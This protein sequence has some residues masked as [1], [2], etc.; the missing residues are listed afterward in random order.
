[1]TQTWKTLTTCVIC[2]N[3]SFRSVPMNDKDLLVRLARDLLQGMLTTAHGDSFTVK[4]V[5]RR[6]TCIVER[7][8]RTIEAPC[9][10][11]REYYSCLRCVIAAE[12]RVE[13]GR[14]NAERDAELAT[15][16]LED[17]D[18]DKFID[19]FVESLCEAH[20]PFGAVL[21]E[22]WHVRRS[23]SASPTTS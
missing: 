14:I 23:F 15:L 21:V 22:V 3:E 17:Q 4:P 11:C 6:G 2:S 18:L 12:L 19:G 5:P 1:M 20:M 10:G 8:A 13:E 9:G 16:G 7:C